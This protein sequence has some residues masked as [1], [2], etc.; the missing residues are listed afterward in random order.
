MVVLFTPHC[1]SMVLITTEC[2]EK[3]III[4]GKYRTQFNDSLTSEL[5]NLKSDEIDE[6]LDAK[7]E[8]EKIL[9]KH[10]LMFNQQ[11]IYQKYKIEI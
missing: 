8:F 9:N 1:T 5:L 7:E 3:E 11:A 4:F 2:Y 6:Y 10:N